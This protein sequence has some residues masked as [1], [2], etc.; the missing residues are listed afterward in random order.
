[1]NNSSFQYSISTTKS[2]AEIFTHLLNPANWW[3]GLYGE[4]IEGKSEVI[5]DEFSFSA[6]NGAHYS[7]Q[8]LTELI[9]GKRI[10]WLVTE[11][12]LSFLTNSNEWAG[13]SICF[14]IEEENGK[15]KIT[16]THEGLVPQFECYGGCS[17]AWEKYLE[18]EARS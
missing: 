13:T 3:V 14:D 10:A 5:N 9:P 2:P 1:M 8:K 12:N 4:R 17:G 18:R 7:R 6:G 11:S 15:T 16:F